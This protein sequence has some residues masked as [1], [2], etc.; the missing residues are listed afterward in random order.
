MSDSMN[1]NAITRAQGDLAAGDRAK[2][3]QRLKSYLVDRPG[4]AE[5][6]RLLTEAYRADGY[7]DEAGRWGYLDPDGATEQERAAYER[8]CAHRRDLDYAP[9]KTRNGLHWPPGTPAPTPYANDMLAFLDTQAT[10]AQEAWEAKIN[11]GPAA[12][13]ARAARHARN[14]AREKARKARRR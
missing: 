12:I 13:L 3:R 8:A 9:I 14:T 4:S 2:A 11:P 6:R 7:L 5:A 10:A 1:V